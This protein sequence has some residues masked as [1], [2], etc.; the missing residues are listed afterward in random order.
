MTGVI[1]GYW[2]LALGILIAAVGLL[3]RIGVPDFIADCSQVVA[4]SGGYTL[5]QDVPSSPDCLDAAAA[6]RRTAAIGWLLM[7]AGVA[8]VAFGLGHRRGAANRQTTAE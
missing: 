7:M 4:V 6:A 3:I 8:V 2:W 5:A 1:R